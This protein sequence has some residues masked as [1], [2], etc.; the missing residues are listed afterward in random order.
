MLKVTVDNDE[1]SLGKPSF[2]VEQQGANWL[3]NNEIFSGDIVR[4]SESRYHVIWNNKSYN[5]EILNSNISDKNIDILIN[6]RRYSTST[7]D[8]IDLL[9]E[10]MGI[11]TQSV[12]KINHIKAPMPGLIQSISVVEGDHVTKGDTLLVLVAMKMENIIKATGD[13]IVKTLKVSA[14][15]TVE[16]NQVML[17]FQ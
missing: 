7:K 13:G 3:V 2:D 17:E 10:G 11:Q 4:L 1:A 16:K 12:Q 14:G 15:E 8:R 5:V 6:G 9:L